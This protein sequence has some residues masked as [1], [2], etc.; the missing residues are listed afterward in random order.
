MNIRYLPEKQKK[1]ASY[2]A[3]TKRSKVA[4]LVRW[5]KRGVASRRQTLDSYTRSQCLQE[6]L[7]GNI[8]RLC[9]IKSSLRKWPLSLGCGE[10]ENYRVLV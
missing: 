4:N 10:L 5:K 9:S 2:I 3:I 1:I 8:S 7:K 6:I